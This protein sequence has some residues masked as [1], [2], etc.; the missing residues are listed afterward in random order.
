MSGT[1]MADRFTPATRQVIEQ[2]KLSV[3]KYKHTHITPEHLLLAIVETND[4]VLAKGFHIGKATP[5]QIKV[6][7]EHHLRIGDILLADDQLTFSERAKRVIETAKDESVK[8]QKT[9]IG[10]EHLLLGLAR[11][12]NTVAAAVLAAV[13]LK[14]DELRTAV[15]S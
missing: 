7:V 1:A 6:L 3:L 9:Q 15:N 11:V 13:D 4:P 2:A 5:A 12:R 8:S 10:P 14:E